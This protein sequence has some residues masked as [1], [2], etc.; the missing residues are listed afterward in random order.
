MLPLQTDPHKEKTSE[1]FAMLW[2][3]QV[4]INSDP[5]GK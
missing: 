3:G 2:F 1:M 5:A 4:Q